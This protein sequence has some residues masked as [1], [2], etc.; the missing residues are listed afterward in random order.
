MVKLD[1]T[2]DGRRQLGRYDTPRPLS[3]SIVD[4]AIRCATDKILEPSSGSGVF[5]ASAIHRLTGLR[6]PAPKSNVWACDIDANACAET[7]NSTGIEPS[8][9]WNGD[10]LSAVSDKGFNGKRFDC[11]V[12]NPPFVSLH[13]MKRMQRKEASNAVKRL[14]ILLDRKASLWAYFI[15]AAIHSLRRG[16]RLA[17]IVPESALH[18]DYARKL[19]STVAARFDRFT[20]LSVRERCFLC[21]GAAER[22]VVMLADNHRTEPKE[23]EILLHETVDVSNAQQ[24]LATSLEAHPSRFPRLNGHAVPHL[25][26]RSASEVDLSKIVDG[27]ALG[28]LAEV[29]IGVVTGANHFFVLSETERRKWKL[30]ESSVIPL[31]PR[32]RHCTGLTFDQE[33]WLKMFERGEK[34]WL[35]FPNEKEH[36]QTILTYLNTFSEIAKKKNKTFEKRSPWFRVELGKT[37]DAFL[38]YMGSTA[39]RLVLA[40]W[41]L[42]CTNTIHRIYFS[43]KL[44]QLKRTAIALSLRS[45]FSQLSAEFEGRAYGSG[46]LKLEPSEARRVRVLLPPKL[47]PGRVAECSLAVDRHLKN[48]CPEAVTT[49][50]DEWLLESIPVL[51]TAFSL[52]SIQN[53]LRSAIRRRL[54]KPLLNAIK[55]T[56]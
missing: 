31:L 44:N 46:V 12:G 49:I 53:A 37:P 18:A 16:G 25:V 17:M 33:D 23:P 1:S 29:K 14:S 5:V 45:S 48:K 24:F 52:N 40:R 36:R 34:C 13:R 2:L 30:P 19:L 54:G 47:S 8:R 50:V 11:V 6:C 39:P 43:K 32:F 42:T 56:D 22:V 51:A 38:Q 15:I 4:W 7:I 20:L 27:Y 3:Q 26:R 41:P 28:D 9:M 10:F 21:H 55:P 35:L